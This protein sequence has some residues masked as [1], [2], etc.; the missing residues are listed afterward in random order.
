[1]GVTI[2]VIVIVVIIVV[3]ALMICRHITSLGTVLVVAY[4]TQFTITVNLQLCYA[5]ILEIV[6]NC[7]YNSN[8]FKESSPEQIEQKLA[9]N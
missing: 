4:F 3:I 2:T 8:V 7:F 5:N 9:G 1:M 6:L